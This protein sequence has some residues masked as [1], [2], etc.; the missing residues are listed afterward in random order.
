MPRDA[1]YV[2]VYDVS[3]DRERDRVAKVLEGFGMRVQ[4]SAFELRLTPATRQTLL[5]RLEALELKSGFLYLYRRAGHRDRTAIG[6]APADPL[7]EA[8]HAYV[9]TAETPPPRET[10]PPRLKSKR[11][12][13]PPIPP[14]TPAAPF[15]PVFPAE[16]G[17]KRTRE[18]RP[19]RSTIGAS[20]QT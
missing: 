3:E 13:A 9:F 19:G 15:N 18:T 10:K 12:P 2:A 8:N 7:D 5:R 16:A 1:S 11:A 14:R 6:Q 4:Y 17:P 20:R